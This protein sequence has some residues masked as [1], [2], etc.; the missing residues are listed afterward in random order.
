MS[1]YSTAPAGTVPAKKPGTLMAAIVLA[2]VSGAAAIANGAMMLAGGAQLAKD[3]VVQGV[4]D[5]AGVTVDQAKDL[6]GS[7]LETEL[8]QIESTVHTRAYLV[9]FAGAVMLLFGLAMGKAATWARVMVTI[10]AV[11]TLGA[12]AIVALDVATSLMKG[13]G[14]AAALGAIV[15]IVVTWLGPNGRYAKV[16]KK[17]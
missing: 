10:G 13:L 12:S 9:I 3:L 11:L 14:W 2:V 4:A 15:T 5:L 6:G 1:T 8:N 16:V 7:F 17:G